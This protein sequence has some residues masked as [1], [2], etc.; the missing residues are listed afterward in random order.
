MRLFAVYYVMRNAYF[1]PL[2]FYSLGSNS[3][4]SVELHL[5][6]TILNFGVC[7]ALFFK[8]NFIFIG[9]KVDSEKLG[10]GSTDIAHKIQSAGIALIGLYYVLDG[11][12][13]AL[14]FYLLS[15]NANFQMNVFNSADFWTAIVSVVGGIVLILVSCGI[16]RLITWLR[17]LGPQIDEDRPRK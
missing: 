16:S 3:G 1:I 15:T 11:L 12:N 6:A 10:F 17:E 2:V 4:L 9:L 13:K 5:L 7:V 14:N 8:P